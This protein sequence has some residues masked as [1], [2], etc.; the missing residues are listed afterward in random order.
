MKFL[1]RFILAPIAI[2]YIG[3]WLFSE[4]VILNCQTKWLGSPTCQLFTLSWNRLL[5]YLSSH[6]V[7]QFFPFLH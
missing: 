2:I 7:I 4:F 1:F 6:G 3:L 5:A